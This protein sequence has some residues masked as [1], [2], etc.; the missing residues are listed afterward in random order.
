MPITIV[1]SLAMFEF[2][3]N[4][5]KERMKRYGDSEDGKRKEDSDKGRKDERSLALV[6]HEQLDWF[7]K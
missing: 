7:S 5:E 6:V 3:A 4:E 2:I 1:V